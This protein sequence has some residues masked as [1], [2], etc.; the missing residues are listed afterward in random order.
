MKKR[1]TTALALAAV[2]GLSGTAAVAV[3]D[4]PAPTP[5]QTLADYMGDDN[6]AQWDKVQT[7]VEAEYGEG[8][9]APTPPPSPEP[10]QDPEPATGIESGEVKWT[11]TGVTF[12]GRI[13]GTNPGDHV[14]I[15]TDT[16]ELTGQRGFYEWEEVRAD[17]TVA[18]VL[19]DY[20]TPQDTLHW[21]I[22]KGGSEFTYGDVVATGTV[23]KPASIPTPEPTTEPTTAPTTPPATGEGTSNGSGGAFT[24]RTFQ[25]FTS[26]GLTSGYHIYASGLDTS[27][28]IGVLMYGDGSGGYG[29]DNPTQSYLIGGTNGLAAVAKKHNLVLVVPNAPAPGCD[30]ED[31]CWYDSTHAAKAKWSSDLMTRIKGQYN[32]DLSRVVVGGYSSGAQWTTQSFLPAHGAAQSV[33]LAVPIAYGGAPRST[34]N[35]PASWKSDVVISWDTGTADEAYTSASYGAIGGR[36]WYRD[37]GFTTDERWPSGVGHSRG[38]EFGA[39]LDREIVQHLK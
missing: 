20:T 35:A 6:D 13:A 21:H 5:G 8:A 10:T 1:T 17:G 4:L 23:S 12:T 38:G 36:N 24:N 15:R 37:N 3:G 34:M 26:N 22:A 27:K 31:N 39:I 7:W 33:D 14:Q 2:L 9:T 11:T 29:Y 30:G 25:S 28:P 18:F 19:A 32:I 16:K